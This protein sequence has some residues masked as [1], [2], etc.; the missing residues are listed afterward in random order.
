M[1]F[2]DSSD[3]FPSIPS[4][5][6]VHLLGPFL[7]RTHQE[8]LTS[9]WRKIAHFVHLK[10]WV[11]DHSQPDVDLDIWADVKRLLDGSGVVHQPL[12]MQAS[13]VK[14]GSWDDK[15]ANSTKGGIRDLQHQ[16]LARYIRDQRIGGAQV[17][18]GAGDPHQLADGFIGSQR[19]VRS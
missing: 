15:I 17:Y 9:E 3:D 5:K 6:Q 18:P 12:G 4:S 1:V 13:M 14:F 8:L 10:V 11:V 7:V 16:Y 2:T 19:S